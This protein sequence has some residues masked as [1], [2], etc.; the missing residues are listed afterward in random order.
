M[1]RPAE[2]AEFICLSC[3]SR[4]ARLAGDSLASRSVMLFE[5]MNFLSPNLS[6]A[7]GPSFVEG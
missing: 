4:S 6:L 1:A 7:A 5:S 3:S 2:A